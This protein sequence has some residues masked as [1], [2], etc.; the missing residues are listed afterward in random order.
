MDFHVDGFHQIH[1]NFWCLF[2]KSCIDSLSSLISCMHHCQWVKQQLKIVDVFILHGSHQF[3]IDQVEQRFH[4]VPW[5]LELKACDLIHIISDLLSEYPLGLIRRDHE[6]YLLLDF[7]K[8]I[9]FCLHNW[10]VTQALLWYC[11][12]SLYRNLDNIVDCQ[13]ALDTC[14]FWTFLCMLILLEKNIRLQGTFSPLF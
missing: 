3:F 4:Q 8:L 12:L 6:V 14:N 13:R 5:K 1:C 11:W 7:L 9:S 2:S 10:Q